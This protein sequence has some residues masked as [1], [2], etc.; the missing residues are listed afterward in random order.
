MKINKR[1]INDRA[2]KATKCLETAWKM[3]SKE[4]GFRQLPPAVILILG[5]DSRRRKSGHFAGSTWRYHS[6]TKKVHEIAITSDLFQMSELLLAVLI[7]EAVHAILCHTE[8]DNTKHYAGCSPDGYYHRVEFRN[9]CRKFGLV[10][11]FR[12][13]R[14]GW[15]ITKWGKEG[16]PERYSKILQ[17]LKT[18]MPLGTKPKQIVAT[19]KELPKSGHSRLECKC[20]DKK[21]GIY[22]STLVLKQGDIICSRCNSEFIF[23][24]PKEKRSFKPTDKD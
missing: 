20:D 2:S 21:R 23:V 3:L 14:H 11:E 12:N 16:V 13:G 10:C 4:L 17:F 18:S 22:V 8:K 15:N 19:G 6:R 1:R 9:K 7:H 5:A 24:K